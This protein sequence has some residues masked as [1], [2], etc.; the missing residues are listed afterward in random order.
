MSGECNRK[1]L[2]CDN[3]CSQKQPA[4]TA[5]CEILASQIENFSL[6]FF[7][8]VFKTE[9]DG[10]VNWSLPCRLDVGLPLNPRGTTEPLGCYFIRLFQSGVVGAMGEQGEPGTTGRNG[11]TPFV[12]VYTAF[13][14]PQVGA[15]TSIQI[16][17]YSPCILPG[18]DI[19]IPGS[20][21]YEVI[22]T[23]ETLNKNRYDPSVG[24]V[25]LVLR[26]PVVQP[27]PVTP[28]GTF[29][30][31]TGK[32]GPTGNTG[33]QGVQGIQGP[34]GV[35]GATGAA[36]PRGVSA[37]TPIIPYAS[38]QIPTFS[39]NYSRVATFPGY[40]G[41]FGNSFSAVS[42]FPGGIPTRL[43]LAHPGSYLILAF[44]AL[45]VA[46]I[47][48]DPNLN[49]QQIDI[50]YGA[51]GILEFCLKNNTTGVFL[52]QST[53]RV[54]SDFF[55]AGPIGGNLPTNSS[56][57]YGVTDGPAGGSGWTIIT[58]F[59]STLTVNNQ[60]QVYARS[61][62]GAAYASVRNLWAFKLS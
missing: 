25:V 14:Q 23:D 13:V 16:F 3:P 44:V 62:T 43:T 9:V 15:P 26:I 52:P 47:V 29:I 39:T 55:V 27:S 51:A 35:T 56:Q 61:I 19:Y 53:V 49:P 31:P 41:G 40:Q 21:W 32:I 6:N 24:L 17:G 50:S 22:D 59:V 36:G 48:I 28:A 58:A 46:P 37:P 57:V 30:L 33:A 45:G 42:L 8:E 5:A 54:A 1:A 11:N 34:Q 20:G 2:Q 18:M 38:A 60:I 12:Q 7:G 10:V 4:N